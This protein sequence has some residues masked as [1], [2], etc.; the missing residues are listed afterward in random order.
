[1][2]SRRK[3]IVLYSGGIDST[4]TLAMARADGFEPLALTF[5]YGQR[6]SVE[7]R[8]AGDLARRLGVEQRIVDLDLGS[9]GGSALTCDA[10]EVPRG[11]QEAEIAA[12]GIPPTYVP[13][14]NTI[15]LSYALAWAEVLGV[16]DIYLGV[17]SVDYSGYPDCRPEFVEAFERLANLA[18]RAAVEGRARIRIHAPL[19]RK[20]KAEIILCGAALGVDFSQ[21]WSCYAPREEG[22]GGPVA[23]GTCD[24]CFL[25]M[26]GFREAGVPDPTRYAAGAVEG[27]TPAPAKP[28]V[29]SPRKR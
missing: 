13:A 24:S 4:T 9:I 29:R 18:T 8:R 17:N 21:T 10:M 26:R 15:F 23:C 20:T 16:A 19:M 1:M 5:R 11:R 7:V 2:D 3:C 28:G 25:R 14:R 22:A 6:H 27:E 12:S